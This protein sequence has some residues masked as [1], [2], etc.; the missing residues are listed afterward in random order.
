MFLC[1]IFVWCIVGLWDTL[2]D[3]G[4]FQLVVSTLCFTTRWPGKCS[5]CYCLQGRLNGRPFTGRVPSNHP[6]SWLSCG[7]RFQFPFLKSKYY[8]CQPDNSVAFTHIIISYEIY[9]KWQCM[10]SD[11]TSDRWN[12]NVDVHLFLGRFT[13]Q[14]IY[15]IVVPF[16]SLALD[17]SIIFLNQWFIPDELVSRRK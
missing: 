13:T 16:Q 4:L 11:D 3:M 17:L 10:D 9:L 2:W 12:D 6:A 14:T 8:Y 5:I 7:S 15:C 1:G